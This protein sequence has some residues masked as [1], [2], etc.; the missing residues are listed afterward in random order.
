MVNMPT[1]S[2]L[3]TRVAAATTEPGQG[4]TGEDRTE[5]RSLDPD[6]RAVSENVVLYAH[7]APKMAILMGKIWEN[8]GVFLMNH[9]NKLNHSILWYPIFR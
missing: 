7:Y 8:M 3:V 6:Q 5:P 9:D 1:L 4:Q 2:C